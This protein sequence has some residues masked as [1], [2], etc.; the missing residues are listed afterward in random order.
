LVHQFVHQCVA[1]APLGF[2]VGVGNILGTLGRGSGDWGMAWALAGWLFI[3]DGVPPITSNQ[4]AC[5]VPCCPGHQGPHSSILVS[6]Q[7]RK[8]S[9]TPAEAS[10]RTAP[11]DATFVCHPV[12]SAACCPLLLLS[13]AGWPPRC[14]CACTRQQGR[15]RTLLPSRRT[16]GRARA[17]TAGGCSRWVRCSRRATA[18]S[19]CQPTAQPALA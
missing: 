7:P 19:T 8:C 5:G 3:V 13:P 18:P 1:S 2:R 6:S 4:P 9:S 17:V 14:L 15:S 10:R 11:S 12:V 16:C